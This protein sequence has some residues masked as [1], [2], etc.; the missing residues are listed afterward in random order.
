M[1]KWNTIRSAL[2]LLPLVA[3]SAGAEIYRYT[4]SQGN[5]EFSDQPRKGAEKIKVKETAT[6]QMPTPADVEAA[7]GKQDTNETESDDGAVYRTLSIA[8]PQDGT[9]FNSGSGDFNV[10]VD[11]DPALKSDHKLRA[12]LDGQSIATSKTNQIPLNNVVRGT[13]TIVVEVIDENDDKV[14]QN[15]TPITFTVHRPSVLN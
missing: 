5:V 2:L 10:V 3:G 7:I 6:I 15:A 14:V 13:H 8:S 1:T 12:S 11:I 9:A 4:D